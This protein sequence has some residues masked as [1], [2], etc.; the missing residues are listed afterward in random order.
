MKSVIVF[1]E[2]NHDVVFVTRSL[3]A[4]TQAKWLTKPV[5]ELPSPFG[6]VPDPQDPRKPKVKGLIA[7]RYSSRTLDDLSIRAAAHPP[8]PSFET[9][10][11]DES[12]NILFTLVR[13]HGDGAFEA[14]MRL[15]DEL[16][17]LMMLPGMHSD[18]KDIAA[19]FLFD[20]DSAGVTG[21]EYEFAERYQR[22]LD[23]TQSPKHAHW[24]QGKS[25]PVGLYVFHE[26]ASKNGTLEDLLAPL[27]EAE[28]P[29]RWRDAG[30]Y[31]DAH[32]DPSAPVRQKRAERYKA[33]VGVTGQVQFPG[34]PMTAVL[35]RRG[36]PAHYFEGQASA[37]LVAF[38]TAAPWS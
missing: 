14:A 7:Q 25:F 6:P 24:V 28:W 20:A 33:Q 11:H 22:M 15:L 31:L 12:K 30:N 2:G 18:V 3:G 1:C 35:E 26:A 10:L 38:L 23:G 29:E 8:Q 32:S 37:E 19:A 13:C 17:D 36:L 4:L 9:L 16:R 34:D 27:V 5:G 21:R